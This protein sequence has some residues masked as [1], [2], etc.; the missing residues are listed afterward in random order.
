L[1]VVR[2]YFDRFWEGA[3][4]NFAVLAEAEALDDGRRRGANAR[5]V[6]KG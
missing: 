1:R 3:L 5:W 4:D 6:K 2:E